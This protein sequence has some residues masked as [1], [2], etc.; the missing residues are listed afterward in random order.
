M[1]FHLDES[2]LLN[3]IEG[4]ASEGVA[5]LSSYA[6]RQP[7]GPLQSPPP[8]APPSTALR[9]YAMAQATWRVGSDGLGRAVRL[10]RLAAAGRPR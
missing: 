8:D 7:P 1:N 5:M 3:L 4:P 10:R 9:S 6:G 2:I